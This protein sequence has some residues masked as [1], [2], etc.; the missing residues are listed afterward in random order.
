MHTMCKAG[1]RPMGI[2]Q[3]LIAGTIVAIFATSSVL[4]DADAERE[5]LARVIHELE[6]IEPL[7]RSAESQTNPDARIRFRYDWLRQDLARVRAG[8]QE[9][10]DATRAEPRTFPPLRGDYRR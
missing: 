4:A 2:T 5:A 1:K 9:H 8:V 10:I 7:I 6:T 3:L